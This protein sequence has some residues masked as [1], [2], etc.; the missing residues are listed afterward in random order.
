MSLL[1][2]REINVYMIRSVL[3]NT[4]PVLILQVCLW[5]F[6]TNLNNILAITKAGI[7]T[8]IAGAPLLKKGKGSS[9]NQISCS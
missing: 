7:Q 1:V 5:M 8:C 6:N 2:I 4:Y 3:L 9:G